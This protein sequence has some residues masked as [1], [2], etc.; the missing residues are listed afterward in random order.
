[1]QTD[2]LSTPQ[3]VQPL[4]PSPQAAKNPSRGYL[5]TAVILAVFLCIFVV[6]SAGLGYWASQ[7]NANLETTQQELSALKSD[8]AKLKDDNQK[9]AADLEQAKTDLEKTK[10]SLTTAQSD[11]KK[12]QDKS[13]SL[14]K[15]IGVAG[16]KMELL[17]I[18]A[19]EMTAQ[20]VLTFAGIAKEINDK[21]I[22]DKWQALLTAPT[23][24][25]NNEFFFFL[26]NNTLDSLK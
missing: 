12:S 5:I 3:E 16:K 23:P 18:F 20:D 10:S 14:E 17:R 1:M 21:Q 26:M 2:P 25:K 4:E 13:K 7:L 11:L 6:A 8:H 15:K 9:L 19:K 22:L 24:E